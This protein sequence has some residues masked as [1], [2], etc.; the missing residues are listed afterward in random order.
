MTYVQSTRYQQDKVAHE[1][2]FISK[3][4]ASQMIYFIIEMKNMPTG[5]T[6]KQQITY[7]NKAWK[8]SVAAEAAYHAKFAPTPVLK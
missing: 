8:M 4:M 1:A 3:Q 7:S 5:L 6:E 2:A